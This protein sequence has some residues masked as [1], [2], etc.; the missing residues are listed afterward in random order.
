MFNLEQAITDWRQRMRAA[1][2]QAPQTLAELESHL[3]DAIE[4][5]LESGL[6]E[7]AAFDAAAGGLGNGRL[8]KREFAWAGGFWGR[9]GEDQATRINR[10]LGLTWVALSLWLFSNTLLVSHERFFQ[11]AAKPTAG[12]L[13]IVLPIIAFQELGGIIGGILLMRGAAGGRYLIMI[14][15]IQVLVLDSIALF[16]PHDHPGKTGYVLAH[17]FFYLVTVGWL[18]P[19][20]ASW[21][22]AR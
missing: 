19:R 6:D 7:P 5:Q 8:L 15:A 2:I 18:L 13:I 21:V 11:D 9:L 4:E 20:R 16:R 14:I 3:R 1:G 12:L 22:K 17:V 10:V